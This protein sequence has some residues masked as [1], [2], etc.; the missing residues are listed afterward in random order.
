MKRC[1]LTVAVTGLNAHDNPG[2][3][4]AVIRGLRHCQECRYHAVGLA[5]DA[6]EPGIYARDIVDEVF[7]VPYPMQGSAA[8]LERIQY[9]RD[10]V[11]LDAIIPTLD[12]EIPSFIA[13]EKDLAEMGIGMFIPTREQFDLRSKNKLAALGQRADLHVPKSIAITDIAALY[14]IHS[15]LP[16][17]FYLKGVLYGAELVHNLDEAL[18]AF[19]KATATWGVPVIL[20][21]A[22]QGEELNVVAVGDGK[23]GLIGAVPMKKTYR[24]EKG[25]GWAGVTVKNSDLLDMTRRFVETV[26]WRGPFELEV[27]VDSDD[28]LHLLEINPRFPAWTYLSAGAGMN[29][30]HAV[31]QLAVGEAVAPM[32]DYRVGTMFVRISQD[33]IASLDLFQ[34]LTIS[35]EVTLKREVAS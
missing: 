25:K 27:V 31:A 23:G 11:G 4:V 16:Y 28:N 30:P 26:K 17:P 1:E 35:G 20:Q 5:Y 10:R 21:E 14:N 24:N 7:L 34:E 12:S 22:V 8:L 6:L 13:I 3:G 2:P 9:I 15:E 32:S 33:L 18:R 29:L 19:H